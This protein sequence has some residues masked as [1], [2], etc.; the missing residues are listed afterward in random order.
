MPHCHF[1]AYCLMPNHFHF[2]ISSDPRTIILKPVGGK[3]INVLSEGIRNLLQTYSKG[4]NKQNG[5]TGSLFQ[6]NT[7]AKAISKGSNLYDLLCFNYIH[8]NPVKAKLVEK[9]EDWQYSSF[10]DYCGLRNGNLCNKELAIQLLG[11]DIKNFYQN[12]YKIINDDDINNIF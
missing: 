11:I 10:R 2:L 7:K 1:L 12:S 9:I 8:Q 5:S 4:I 6:Q 3:K